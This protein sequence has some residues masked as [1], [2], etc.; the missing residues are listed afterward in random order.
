MPYIPCKICNKKFYSKPSWINRGK[1]RFCSL[2]C[3]ARSRK[4]GATIKCFVC[5]KYVYRS[6]KKI[7][8]SHSKK[9]FCTRGCSTSWLAS[10]FIGSKHPNWRYGEYSYKEVMNRKGTPPQCLVCA[11]KNRAVIIVHHVDKNRKNNVPQN[12]MWL[13]RNCHFLVHHYVEENNKLLMK[14]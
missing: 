12:L 5:G 11:T 1:G 7:K 4:T 9:F 3:Y 14:I 10:Q 8:K 13:C 6:C 2:N